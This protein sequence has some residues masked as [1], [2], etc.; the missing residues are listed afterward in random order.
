MTIRTKAKITPLT[1][2]TDCDTKLSQEVIVGG[3]AKEWSEELLGNHATFRTGPF[4]SALHKSDYIKNGVPLINP[5]H[6]VDGR[7]VPTDTMTVSAEVASALS[8]F[9]LKPGEIVIGRRGDMGRCAVVRDG[10][11]GWLCGTGSMIVRPKGANPDF[12]Q[13]I[14]SS[15]EVVTNIENTSVGTTM[16]NLN[17][18]TLAGLKV[19]LPPRCEQDAIVEVLSDVDALIEALKKLIAKKRLIKQ[20]A[21]QE[22]L[23]PQQDWVELTL[24]SS[25]QLKARIGWQGL[26]TGEYLDG[27]DYHLV[28]G[29]DFR[30]GFIDWSNCHF[31]D[32]YR[33]DQDKN[34]QLRE[35]DVLVTKDGTIGKVAFIENLP[36][37]ATLNSGVFVVRPRTNALQPKFL[38]YLLMSPV[39]EGFL[40]RLSAG[41]TISHLYQKDFV[42]F[43]FLIPPTLKRQD[44]IAAALLEM[45][46]DVKASEA[47]LAKAQQMKQALMQELLTGRIR[48]V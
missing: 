15:S 10:Q 38:Y 2:T 46:L 14:L 40:A 28:T 11:S 37:P 32:K 22:L 1:Q 33:Y 24:G 42:G 7:I 17:Q 35:N 3:G 47:R 26:T 29:T 41:S 9:Q 45:D 4:G 39:F 21:M 23:S 5:M 6:I 36:Q 31:V 16:A 44:E 19:Q 18:D 8:E 20:G 25:A 48:L 34:I 13:R 12:L 27:G 30:D 43:S